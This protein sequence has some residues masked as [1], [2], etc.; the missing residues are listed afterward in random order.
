MIVPLAVSLGVCVAVSPF[1]CAALRARSILDHPN[2]RSSHTTPT[3]RGGGVAVVMAM[4]AGL[5]ASSAAGAPVAA[6]LVGIGG[7]AL[8]GLVEDVQG[9]AALPRLGL[10]FAT[11]VLALPWLLEGS[12]GSVL[13]RVSFAV[14]VVVALVGYANAFNFMDGINGIAA[15]QASLAGAVFAVA[16]S[17]EGVVVL[18]A[19][20]MVLIGASVAFLPFNVPSAR[21]FL[22]DVG[23]Y[24]LGGAIATLAV[25]AVRS[26]V[27]VEAVAGPLAVYLAD[28]TVT[29]VRRIARHERIWA[30][31]RQH[32]YQQLVDGGWS[33]V[34]TTA[35]AGLATATCS[36]LGFVS[37]VGGPSRVVADL[38]LAGVLAGY[39]FAPRVLA[40]RYLLPRG[41]A[42]GRGLS[43][44]RPLV[45][46]E[47]LPPRRPAVRAFRRPLVTRANMPAEAARPRLAIVASHPIQY[48]V[49]LFR[50]LTDAGRVDP[51]VLFLSDFGVEPTYDP[52]FGRAVRFDVALTEGFS[53]RFVPK[54]G[55]PD[56]IEPPFG[57]VN[58]SLVRHLR[59]G[60]YDAVL[61]HGYAQVSDWL[62]FVSAAASGARLL[63]RGESQAP[64]A[65]VEASWRW[66]VKR[67]VLA[68]VIR[69]A[70]ACLAIGQRNA[71][72]Y[73]RMGARADQVVWAPYSVDNEH[74]AKCGAA[75]RLG[76]D[77]ELDALGLDAQLPVVVFAAKL[78]PRKRV[79]DLIAAMDR[80]DGAA[81]LIVI[82]DG[83][84]RGEVA[85]LARHRPWIR[86]LG[87]LNQGKLGTWYG[88]SDIVVLPS[89]RETWGITVNEAMAAGA[90][91]VVSDA[92]GC[93][94]DLVA[95]GAGRV[96]PVGDV[97]A[98]ARAIE[99][100]L[101]VTTLE[102]ART[103]SLERV[104]RFS[105]ATTV[106]GIET[107]VL[108]ERPRLD[109]GD[110]CPHR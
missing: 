90:V 86:A 39:L 92:V 33:H 104:D 66:R 5:L 58:P 65:A 37:F 28:T 45:A 91:P 82:G 55:A 48:Q 98:L 96:F 53:H 99:D 71:E 41:A 56:K 52:G 4:A 20:G 64:S 67:S 94:P 75:G 83:E 109:Q 40:R 8:V 38:A 10:L 78:I 54:L 85:S 34:G 95:G 50:A 32:T 105:L 1:L 19:G 16:G 69:R 62:A 60:R 89:D 72:F 23:S 47:P 102:E 88:A 21:M 17:I 24:G 26:G 63:L 18:Q 108:R 3:P 70:D 107:A 2:A 29:L 44:L 13:W 59:A 9:I 31:H 76:R 11:A 22:G 80:L 6:L 25:L 61:V 106:A 51:K 68:P 43:T 30:G 87:F 14:A 7:F 103:R 57:L 97:V 100:L 27:P 36:V 15:T 84:Q 77:A 73:Y 46:Q 81:S 79:L 49:P 93:A 42:S 35:F 110:R 74:F 12:T 101:D